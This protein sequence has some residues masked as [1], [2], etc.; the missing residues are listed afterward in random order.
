MPCQAA[1]W[2][3]Q[4]QPRKIS[5]NF[6]R[7]RTEPSM[8]TAPSLKGGGARTSRRIGVSPRSSSLGTRVYPRFPDPPVSS[9]FTVFLGLYF[10]ICLSVNA[11]AGHHT[12]KAEQ[13][14]C[15]DAVARERCARSVGR[16]FRGFRVI[17]HRG[18]ANTPAVAC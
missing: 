5:V 8:N 17:E 10:P 4:S 16:H 7:S 11:R 6:E 12:Q 15:G 2:T 13:Y 18:Q 1:M 14:G 9:T 3:M